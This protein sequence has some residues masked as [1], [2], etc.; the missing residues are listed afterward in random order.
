MTND[1]SLEAFKTKAFTCRLTVCTMLINTKHTPTS[2]IKILIVKVNLNANM[3][4]VSSLSS[5]KAIVVENANFSVCS[6]GFKIHF[7]ARSNYEPVSI[8]T[9]W[10]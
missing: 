10:D 5:Q 4:G 8:T 2:P 9:Q 3:F 7:L 6:T 1:G